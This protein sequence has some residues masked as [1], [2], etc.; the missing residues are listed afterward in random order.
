MKMMSMMDK[1]ID[2]KMKV[3]HGKMEEAFESTMK[4]K[5]NASPKMKMGMKKMSSKAKAYMKRVGV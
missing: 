3:K 4:M 2:K 5:K 1:K